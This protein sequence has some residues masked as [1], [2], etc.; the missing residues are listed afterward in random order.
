MHGFLRWLHACSPQEIPRGRAWDGRVVFR[1]DF[2][3]RP[4][5]KSNAGAARRAW[6]AMWEG[7]GEGPPHLAGRPERPKASIGLIL[8]RLPVFQSIVGG[9][10]LEGG[11]GGLESLRSTWRT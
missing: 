4:N 8:P 1:V 9:R 7:R 6:G 11:Y 2:T 3:R 5:D 10:E